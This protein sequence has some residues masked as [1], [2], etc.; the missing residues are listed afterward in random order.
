LQDR[1]AR[2]GLDGIAD[3]VVAADQG[4]LVGAE[5]A[6]HYRARIDV[7]R[8]AEPACQLGG[9]DVFDEET[10]VAQGDVGSAGQ[11]RHRGT[12]AGNGAAGDNGN[13]GGTADA[14]ASAG[15][16]FTTV[17][18]P[19]WPQPATAAQA[20]AVAAANALGAVDTTLHERVAIHRFYRP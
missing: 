5:R 9:R 3:Q 2:V 19:F 13:G 10:A 12:G 17:S 16:V 20:R 11:R 18:G 15:E 6:F 14:A 1:E 8:R 7:Q 4:T